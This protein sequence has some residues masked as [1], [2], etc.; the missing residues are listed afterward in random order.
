MK[1]GGAVGLAGKAMSRFLGHMR[2]GRQLKSESDY[3]AALALLP[4]L[5][6]RRVNLARVLRGL[7]DLYA[8]T[9]KCDDAA[10]L[11]ARLAQD[12]NDPPRVFWCDYVRVLFK[13]A[14]ASLREGRGAQA[15]QY[16]EQAAAT[17]ARAKNHAETEVVAR[18]GWLTTGGLYE[19]GKLYFAADLCFE[20]AFALP[21]HEA[22]DGMQIC[23]ELAWRAYWRREELRLWHWIKRAD[24]LAKDGKSSFKTK[25]GQPLARLASCLAALAQAAQGDHLKDLC[26]KLFNFGAELLRKEGEALRPELS[27]LLVMWGSCLTQNPLKAELLMQE[28][29]DLREVIWGSEHPKVRE[30]RQ[31]LGQDGGGGFQGGFDAYDPQVRP[32][33]NARNRRERPFSPPRVAVKARAA[34]A[35][36]IKRM[37]RKLVKL[38]HPDQAR[39]PRDYELRNRL[40]VEINDAAAREDAGA[41]SHLALRARQELSQS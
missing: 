33:P 11:Y 35:E 5:A 38:T 26:Q 25:A 27:D 17:Q 34:T 9:G 16:L 6:E 24:E 1:A 4:E 19:Q 23:A 31:A 37:H 2:R 36:E 32:Q 21:Y 7:A 12:L 10:A 15:S 13:A 39:N 3:L 18:E 8:E 40:T 29:L 41:L 28:A 14:H 30:L 22:N 20:R